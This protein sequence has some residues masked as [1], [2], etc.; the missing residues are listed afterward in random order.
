MKPKVKFAK[1]TGVNINDR[2]VV[3]V[4]LTM[5]TIITTNTINNDNNNKSDN[6]NLHSNFAGAGF[7]HPH[8]TLTFS[9]VNPIPL[10]LFTGSLF[11]CEMPISFRGPAIIFINIIIIVN[12]SSLSRQVH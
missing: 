7:V 8:I 9:A 2:K 6:Y 10:Q 11:L 1:A 4:I 3:M 5:M 12:I